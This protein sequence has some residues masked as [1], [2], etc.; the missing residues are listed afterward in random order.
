MSEPNEDLNI[1]VSHPEGSM[2]DLI[3]SILISLG[4]IFITYQLQDDLGHSVVIYIFLA[5]FVIAITYL[6]LDVFFTEIH[7]T[8]SSLSNINRI[9]GQKKSI[10]ISRVE[11]CHSG[12]RRKGFTVNLHVKMISGAEIDLTYHAKRLDPYLL[13]EIERH[14][15]QRDVKR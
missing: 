4:L 11:R 6:S 15:A 13:P 5:V 3:N 10:A 8:N 1:R 12:T 2:V 7:L 14:R 9:T